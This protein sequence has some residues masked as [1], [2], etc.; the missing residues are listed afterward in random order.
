MVQGLLEKEYK[1]PY[2][3]VIEKF[4]ELYNESTENEGKMM[5][6]IDYLIDKVIRS[7]SKKSLSRYYRYIKKGT[8][9]YDIIN[10]M[11]TYLASSGREY[12]YFEVYTDES[13]TY[14]AS[15][16]SVRLN[17]CADGYLPMETVQLDI[18]TGKQIGRAH[19]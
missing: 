12:K 3:T 13:D 9:E 10:T 8:K 5:V 7:E 17:V 15:I 11:Y 16:P 2:N 1:E 19:V 14:I 18:V 6:F 4:T